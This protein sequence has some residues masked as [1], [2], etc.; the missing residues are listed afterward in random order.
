VL[1]AENFCEIALKWTWD[2][3]FWLLLRSESITPDASDKKSTQ[4]NNSIEL[5]AE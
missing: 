5:N 1:R 2:W 3:S 4:E